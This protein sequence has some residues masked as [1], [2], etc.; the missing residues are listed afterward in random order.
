VRFTGQ[1]SKKAGA[2]ERAAIGEAPVKVNRT[3]TLAGPRHV[4]ILGGSGSGTTTLGRALAERAG[5]THLDSDAFYWLPTDPPFTQSRPVEARVALL[6]EAMGAADGWVLSGSVL[7][8]GEP[9]YETFD[10]IVFLY[11]D[12]AIRLE[13]LRQR[14]KER[15]GA[16][17]A[18]GEPLHDHHQAF[19]DYARGYDRDDFPG[20][21]RKRHLAWLAE[22]ACPILELDG[23]ASVAQNLEAV[24][25]RL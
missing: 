4:H 18:P 17:I 2:G 9:F 14:E 19:L 11:L 8:W 24:M 13:R 23:V 1:G 21:S 5:L 20:R 16:A 7:T 10:L 12:P 6:G 15:Y 25:A 22:R 3:A